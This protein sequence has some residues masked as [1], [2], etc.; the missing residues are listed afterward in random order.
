MYVQVE[1]LREIPKISSLEMHIVCVRERQR[2][3]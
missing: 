2:E 3:S 1:M